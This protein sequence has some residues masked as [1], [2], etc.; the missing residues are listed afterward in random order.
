MKLDINKGVEEYKVTPNAILLDV[1]TVEEYNEGHIKGSINW[2]LDQ[3]EK[4]NYPK[5]TPLF[6]HCRSGRR[7]EEAKEILLELGYKKVKN[8]GGILDYTGEIEK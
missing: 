6:V 8:I 2:P 1:R 4:V 3:I 7:S 5:D